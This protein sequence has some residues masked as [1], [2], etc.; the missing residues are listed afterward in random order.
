VTFSVNRKPNRCFKR[1]GFWHKIL[2][3]TYLADKA[4][5]LAAELEAELAESEVEKA[6][7]GFALRINPAD[8][9]SRWYHDDIIRTKD[10]LPDYSTLRDSLLGMLNE[11]GYSL[12]D[13][14]YQ[15]FDGVTPEATAGKPMEGYRSYDA[16][17]KGRTLWPAE[18]PRTVYP[19]SSLIPTISE[20]AIA[21]KRSELRAAE[22]EIE[23]IQG[24]IDAGLGSIEEEISTIA[25][26]QLT[27]D[28]IKEMLKD[29]QVLSPLEKAVVDWII[30]QYTEE[31]EKWIDELQN[32]Q[33]SKG[34]IEK[35][36]AE[37]AK[38][39]NLKIEDVLEL[40]TALAPEEQAI[41]DSVVTGG[42]FALA[43][44]PEMLANFSEEK[45]ELL[46][47]KEPE[48]LSLIEEA[49]IK[50]VRKKYEEE[51][52]EAAPTPSPMPTPTPTPTTISTET[53]TPT[54]LPPT[55]TPTPVPPTNTP[56]PAPSGMVY[57]PTGEFIMGSGEGESNERPVHMVYLDAFFTDRTEVTNAQ[58]GQCVEAGACRAPITCTWGRSTYEDV[59]KA[60]HPVVW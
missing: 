52:E 26:E 18:Q 55:D 35:I 5:Q 22:A 30:A 44:L 48:Q 50:F 47:S 42:E 25:Q 6:V 59:S 21:A 34:S 13:F 51:E 56:P 14:A 19:N 4:D 15:W 10:I 20:E 11:R 3:R 36:K 2:F 23:R 49:L 60:D 43:E 32:L 7:V 54:P 24:E 33:E 57:V 17:D 58:Y 53:P 8:D 16:G 1:Q 29:Y 12:D 38:I 9:R 41:I 45:M 27:P 40:Y 28:G 39:D 37:V 46:L 31:D